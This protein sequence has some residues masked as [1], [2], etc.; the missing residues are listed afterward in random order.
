M[1]RGF[2]SECESH[3]AAVRAEIGL[4]TRAPLDPRTLASH[5]DI[6]VRPVSS[7]VGNGVIQAAVRYVTQVDQT[8]LSAM[9]IFPDWPAHRRVIIFNDAHS[10][11]R[12]NSDIAHELSHGL[13]MH[14]PRHAVVNGCRDYSKAEE[15]EAAW[16]AG[17]L[18]V[19]RDAAFNIAMSG[20]PLDM[21]AIEYGVSTKLMTW[22]VNVTGVR[23]QARLV[24]AQ[25]GRA[26]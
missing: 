9:T 12:Q 11:A 20:V 22:R 18:L 7:L 6:P 10:P 14:E 5:L 4:D 1:E 24:R 15:E 21:A 16:L 3:A 19:P 8:V 26:S 2:K 23:T 17:C 13:R 25:E